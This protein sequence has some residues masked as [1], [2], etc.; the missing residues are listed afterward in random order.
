MNTAAPATTTKRKRRRYSCGPCKTLKIKCNLQTPCQACKKVG[1]ED[2]CYEDPPKPPSK[3]EINISNRRKKLANRKKELAAL[4]EEDEP[5]SDANIKGEKLE[6]NPGNIQG[7]KR[8][9]GAS[10]TGSTSITPVPNS[11]NVMPSSSSNFEESMAQNANSAILPQAVLH[12]ID[13]TRNVNLDSSYLSSNSFRDLFASVSST[14]SSDKQISTSS[15]SR[16]GSLASSLFSHRLS[17]GGLENIRLDP[18]VNNYEYHNLNTNHKLN[19]MYSMGPQATDQPLNTHNFYLS[20][21]NMT[22]ISPS[23]NESGFHPN[24]TPIELQDIQNKQIMFTFNNKDLNIFKSFL[25]AF[26]ILEELL[27]QYKLSSSHTYYNVLNIEQIFDVFKDFFNIISSL[28]STD[29]IKIDKHSL[30]CISHFYNIMAISY[31]LSGWE[32]EVIVN[33]DKQTVIQGWIN[34]SSMIRRIILDITKVSD[35]LFSIEWYLTIRD[36]FK[37]NNLVLD[38]YSSFSSVIELLKLNAWILETIK[39]DPK[40]LSSQKDKDVFRVVMYW[41]YLRLV[42]LEVPYIMS[43]GTFIDSPEFENSIVPDKQTFNYLFKDLTNISDPMSNISFQIMRLYFNRTQYTASAK[44]FLKSYLEFFC[45]LSSLTVNDIDEFKRRISAKTFEQ[46]ESDLRTL[47]MVQFCQHAAI[48][49]I[50]FMNIE[51]SHYFPS[52]RFASYLTTVL[53][54]FNQFS[55]LDSAIKHQT[56]NR[57]CLVDKLLQTYSYNCFAVFVRS[58]V[59]QG[60]FVITL[61]NFNHLTDTILNFREIFGIAKSRFQDT[62][63]LFWNSEVHSRLYLNLRFFQNSFDLC[64]QMIDISEND[65]KFDLL[66]DFNSYL[67]SDLPLYEDLTLNYFASRDNLRLYLEILWRSLTHIKS[68]N[69]STELII[70]EL[71]NLNMDLLNSKLH[72]LT[73]LMVTSEIVDDF[74]KLV[75]EPNTHEGSIAHT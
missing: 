74:T 37:Y 13:N 49:W 14:S 8:H 7:K 6:D 68:S 29:I 31:L 10:Y 12:L 32:S 75:I 56:Q 43:K 9:S 53:N 46:T 63:T 42:D 61:K 55:R 27:H 18:D 19:E 1:R 50:S 41:T 69:L 47:V 2:K 67:M 58:L 73:G 38:D 44:L 52:L 48:R 45:D 71:L 26:P 60:I 35:I 40:K 20:Q 25:P 21:P 15:V 36:F 5:L 72:D 57:V 17:S 54:L 65:L 11:L 4:S 22:M 64:L 30:K 39:K 3:E 24:A 51:F 23:I 28:S 62:F 70:S 59:F 34:I 33:L 66:D 16:S